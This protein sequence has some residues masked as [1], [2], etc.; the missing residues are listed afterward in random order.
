MILLCLFFYDCFLGFE[1][2]PG[3]FHG[4]LFDLIFLEF[5][6]DTFHNADNKV[7]PSDTAQNSEDTPQAEDSS[8][9]SSK[10]HNNEDDREYQHE[11]EG[12]YLAGAS[13]KEETRQVEERCAL[14]SAHLVR[15]VGDQ[16]ENPL[17][18]VLDKVDGSVK[19]ILCLGDKLVGS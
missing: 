8:K 11:K 9:Q 13:E 1:F 7:D 2:S 18:L 17:D 12:L 4:L 5:L 10:E 3:F 16:I 19:G 14:S 15:K 6:P